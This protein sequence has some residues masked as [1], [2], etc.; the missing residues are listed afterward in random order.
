MLKELEITAWGAN[1]FPQQCTT[2]DLASADFVVAVKEAEHRPLMRDR[3]AEWEHVPNYWHVDDVEDA[4]PAEALRL[5]TWQVRTL[6]QQFR[7]APV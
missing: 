5:L 3:F 7:K 4:P 2:A 1:R 6:L